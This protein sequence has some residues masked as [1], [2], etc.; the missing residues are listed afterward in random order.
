VGKVRKDAVQYAERNQHYDYLGDSDS[1][2][3]CHVINQDASNGN[4]LSVLD[5]FRIE[6]GSCDVVSIIV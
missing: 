5:L 3:K 4:I 1:S 6:L 2:G